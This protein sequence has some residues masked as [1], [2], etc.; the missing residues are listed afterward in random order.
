[1]NLF[2]RP[3]SSGHLRRSAGSVAGLFLLLALLSAGC[4]SDL[5]ILPEESEYSAAGLKLSTYV[6]SF[7]PTFIGQAST[8]T[9][10]VQYGDTVQAKVHLVLSDTS[11]FRVSPDSLSLNR[12][13]KTGSL[14]VTFTPTGIDSVCHTNLYLIT[15]GWAD[16]FHVAIDTVGIDSVRVAGAGQNF[17]LDLEMVFIPGGTFIMGSDSS[18]VDSIFYDN[19]D[20]IPAHEVHLSSFLIGRYEVTNM[21]YYEFWREEGDSRTPK[22]TSG[23][24]AWPGVAL[25]KPNFP[26]IGVSWEDAV[27]FCRWLSLRTGAHYTLPTEAQWEYVARG[28]GAREYPWSILEDEPV[29][30]TELAIPLSMRANVKH[31][32]DGYTFTAPVEAFPA[33]AS[34]FG[35][36]NMAGNAAEWCLDWYNPNYYAT[37]QTWQDPQGSTDLENQF[38]RVVRG[39]SYLTEIDQTRTANRSAVA[40]DNREIDIGFRLV[41]LP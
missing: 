3:V 32:G 18:A 36:L 23:I 5:A 19:R 24:G 12:T 13:T 16:T 8:Q 15:T 9:V 34:A 11:V 41:R 33:G 25:S 4:N 31:G 17:Y 30:S 10:Q 27:A 14:T 38:Y 29:D 28:G 6:I 21:Q 1:M 40:P 2:E 26:V 39:G 35:P 37:E 20:E 7:A 22:D